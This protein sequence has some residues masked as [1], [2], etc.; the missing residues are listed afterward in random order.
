MTEETP[1]ERWQREAVERKDCRTCEHCAWE[2]DSDLYC[3][4]PEA[5]KQVSSFGAS[6]GAM[7]RQNLCKSPDK[8]LWEGPRNV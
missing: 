2:P 8:A 7:E 6:F 4:H 1:T 3:G 5:F